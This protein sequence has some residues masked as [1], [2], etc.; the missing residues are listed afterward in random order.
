MRKR[1]ITR[2]M[3]EAALEKGWCVSQ[4]ARHYEF[5]YSSID[6]ACQR[7]GIALPMHKYSPALLSSRAVGP[8]PS[9]EK[10]KAWS[11]SPDAIR[12]A[13]AKI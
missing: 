2:D 3:I 4:T 12:R 7:F 11:A 8:Q 10:V 1:R 9:D 6:A 13:L 5:H